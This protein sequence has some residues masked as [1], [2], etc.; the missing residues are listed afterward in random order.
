MGSTVSNVVDTGMF[1]LFLCW[2]LSGEA[3]QLSWH[4]VVAAW[5]VWAGLSIAFRVTQI[6]ITAWRRS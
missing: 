5:A 6:V 1:T 4:G 3:I 2:L